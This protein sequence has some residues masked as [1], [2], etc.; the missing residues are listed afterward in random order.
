MY[1]IY[2]YEQHYTLENQISY[3]YK[4]MKLRLSKLQEPLPVNASSAETVQANA[5][6]VEGVLALTHLFKGN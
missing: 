6:T 1:L 5:L 2:I 4:N 3:E